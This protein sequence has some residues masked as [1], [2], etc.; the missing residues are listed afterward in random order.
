M[1]TIIP[2]PP[3]VNRVQNSSSLTIYQHIINMRFFI[4]FILLI[5]FASCEQFNGSEKEQFQQEIKKIIFKISIFF[6]YKN[7]QPDSLFT[8]EVIQNDSINGFTDLTSIDLIHGKASKLLFERCFNILDYAKMPSFKL[9]TD[10][11]DVFPSIGA[12]FIYWLPS[13]NERKAFIAE[14]TQPSRTPP[15]RF[16][17]NSKLNNSYHMIYPSQ[18]RAVYIRIGLSKSPYPVKGGDTAPHLTSEE[19]NLMAANI[20]NRKIALLEYFNLVERLNQNGWSHLNLN[21]GIQEIFPNHLFKT[22]TLHATLPHDIPYNIK[23]HQTERWVDNFETRR[24][25]VLIADTISSSTV[26]IP[27]EW[28]VYIDQFSPKLSK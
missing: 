6:Y 8:K 27:I 3:K 7:Y 13:T 11:S 12:P 4:T 18:Q 21:T 5:F 22:I 19:Y 24:F 17:S 16:K 1:L 26:T 10:S 14:L 28:S 9:F 15:E 2:L 25:H 23:V 20:G